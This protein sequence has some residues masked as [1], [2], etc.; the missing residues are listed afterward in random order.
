MIDKYKLNGIIMFLGGMLFLIHQVFFA[1]LGSTFAIDYLIFIL[2][3]PL[4]FWGKEIKNLCSKNQYLYRC[5]TNVG[6]CFLF[7]F[8]VLVCRVM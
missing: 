7:I 5:Y 1:K 8:A 2:Y 6:F 3:S 4:I